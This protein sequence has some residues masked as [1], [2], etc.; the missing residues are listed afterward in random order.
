M[1]H[2]FK[3]SVLFTHARI[4]HSSLLRSKCPITLKNKIIHDELP[5]SWFLLLC[6]D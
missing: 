3:A 5:Q 6:F 2:V 4:T 1:L